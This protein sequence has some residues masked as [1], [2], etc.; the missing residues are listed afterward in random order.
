MALDHAGDAHVVG[1]TERNLPGQRSAGGSDFFVRKY[2]VSGNEMWTR[3]FGTDDTDLALAVVVDGTGQA[4]A[5]G[6]TRGALPGQASAGGR[7]AVIVK[8]A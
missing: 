6:S 5:I 3:Q 4:H 2:D 1:S 8:L 7:D